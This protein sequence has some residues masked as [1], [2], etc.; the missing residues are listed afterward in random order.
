L[1]THEPTLVASAE[2]EDRVC[3]GLDPRVRGDER[4]KGSH[5]NT[6]RVLKKSVH[7]RDSV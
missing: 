6:S 2:F 5:W 4:W 7:K 1:L 3:E